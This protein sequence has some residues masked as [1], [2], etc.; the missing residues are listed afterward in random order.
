MGYSTKDVELLRKEVP[1]E[2]LDKAGFVSS[3]ASRDIASRLQFEFERLLPKVSLKN[4][5]YLL[6]LNF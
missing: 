2:I 3:D 1:Q 4:F 6:F 5:I